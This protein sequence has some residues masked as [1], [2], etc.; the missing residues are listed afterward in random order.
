MRRNKQDG[1][2]TSIKRESLI[3]GQE[4]NFVSF[5]SKHAGTGKNTP[6]GIWWDLIHSDIDLIEIRQRLRQAYE[7]NLPELGA[8][9]FTS[10]CQCNCQHC[11]YHT[12]YSKF[13]ACLSSDQWKRIVRNIYDNLGIKTFIHNGRSMDDTGVKVLKWMREEFP[14]VQIGLIDNGISLNSYLDELH[15]IQ[16]DWIDIS[17]DGMEKEH[18]LQRNRT[19]FFKETF[20]TIN[21]L[22][23]EDI[24]PKIN[25]LSCLTTINKDSVINLI[26]FMNQ[27]GF[28]NFFVSPV[29][30]F[31]DY[32]PSEK[33]RVTGVDLTKFIRNLY[34]SLDKLKDTWIEFNIFDAEYMKYI[35]MFYPELW[36]SLYTKQ[37]YLSYGMY[38]DD[39]ELYVNYHPL[40]LNGIREF[41]INS[42]GD[43]ILPQA[44]R[45]QRIQDEDI[46]GSLLSENA[47]ETIN[48]LRRFKLGFYVNALTVEK[49][50]IGGK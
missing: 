31:K 36:H 47:S 4:K 21:R 18:D 1:N 50:F 41:I 9:I 23:Q 27:N 49:S 11:I 24:A 30:T 38:L 46:I 37:K 25:I 48:K 45:K 10:T 35:K 7:S 29:C 5:R 3:I 14:D 39:N 15:D 33:L 13:N 34:S 40:S 43:V 17:I 42:N 19:G 12:D 8:I 44:V 2:I 26:K 20:K 22:L 6:I 28:K 16:P 32:G